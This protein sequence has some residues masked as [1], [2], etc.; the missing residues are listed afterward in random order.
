MKEA[1]AF[2]S[3]YDN[4]YLPSFCRRVLPIEAFAL[5]AGLSPTRLFG[6]IVECGRR[7]EAGLGSLT[8]AAEHTKIVEA[9]S[10]AALDPELGL[11][12]R[13]M[14]LKHMGFLPLPKGSQVNVQVNASAVAASESAALSAGSAPAPEDTIRRIVEARQ[15]RQLAS[16]AVVPALPESTIDAESVPT[17]LPLAAREPV[18]IDADQDSEDDD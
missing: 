1:R 17:F 2:V 10:K 6:V 18:T 14:H 9:S 5:A 11:A 15:A 3:K 16:A 4:L 12:D 8:A 7:F 13:T